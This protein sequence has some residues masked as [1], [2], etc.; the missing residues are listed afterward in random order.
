ME[1]LHDN[2]CACLPRGDAKCNCKSG[3]SRKIRNKARSN[4]KRQRKK[5][6]ERTGLH[7]DDTLIEI[8]GE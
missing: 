5:I 4:L 2:G 1:K 8:G 7:F 6:A 3:K